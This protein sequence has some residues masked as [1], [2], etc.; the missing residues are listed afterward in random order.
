MRK[1]MLV[2]LCFC[3]L[4]SCALPASAEEENAPAVK[5]NI[6]TEDDFLEFAEK[7]RLDSYSQN[8]EVYLKSDLNLTGKIFNGIPI[9]CG[10]L[11][12]NDHT[13]EGISIQGEGSNQGFFRY[14][15]ESAEVYKLHLKGKVNPQGSSAKAGGFAGSN[16]GSIK[17][18]SFE[19]EVSGSDR[20]GGIAGFNRVD[21]VID[22][23]EVSGTVH[24]GHFVGGLAGENMG[25]IRSCVNDADIN[26]E[27]NQNKVDLSSITL[28]TISGV[29]AANIVTDI[30]GIAGTNGGVIRNCDNQAVVGYLHIGYN[31]GGIA[32]SQKGY[33]FGCRNFGPIFGRKEVGGIVGQMEPVTRIEYTEDTL[34]ILEQQLAGTAALTSQAAANAKNN[35]LSLDGQI[36][37]LKGQAETARDAVESLIPS[38]DNPK[39]PDRDSIVAAKNALDSSMTSMQNTMTGIATSAGNAAKALESDIRAISGQI[40]AMSH[41][42]NEASDHFGATFTD[43]SDEDTED[44]LTGKVADCSNSGPISGDLNA[45]GIIGAIAWE[46][47]LDPEDDIQFSGENSLKIESEIRAVVLNCRNKGKIEVKRRNA[48]GIAGWVSLGLL[49]DCSNS[50]R[51]EAED[52]QY[53]GGI[54]GNSTGFIRSCNSKCEI[55]GQRYVG[56]IAGSGTV[57]TDSRSIAKI[58]GAAEQT[59]EILGILNLSR[60]DTVENFRGNY[61]M[62]ADQDLGAVDG[63][64][65]ADRAESLPQ[66]QFY[67]LPELDSVFSDSTVTFLTEEGTETVI[68]MKP[69][70]ILDPSLI[71]AVPEKAGYV[72]E[73]ENLAET[74]EDGVFFDR[75]YKTSYTAY[76]TAIESAEEREDGRA[77]LLAEGEFAGGGRFPLEPISDLPAT[78]KDET[79]VEGWKVPDLEQTGGIQL[80]YGAPKEYDPELLKVMIQ[81]HDGSWRE[82]EV[83]ISE[84]YLIF[85]AAPGDRAFSVI[86]VPEEIPWLLYIGSGVLGVTLI[87]L[88][89]ILIVR[90]KKKKNKK[91]K[92][93]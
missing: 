68:T 2:A 50:G 18:C 23:C 3:I 87:A 42:L 73:W 46:N 84:S 19:G 47:D 6:E 48:G 82:A 33:L 55:T 91:Q 80:R 51:I 52:V 41:T 4:F 44:E 67:S 38:R 16:A 28:E 43:V 9:F 56:G 63:I 86:A 69:G 29:E 12:G 10:K 83:R 88:A 75:T 61:Y 22:Q 89:V 92:S 78:E 85:T 40:N 70:E 66:E 76:R 57:V 35:A 39:L 13:I 45:G 26:A 58:S 81:D 49:R 30:G 34:Q 7:C 1:I 54:V 31:I 79:A 27:A 24:G 21:G 53:V 25:V 14:L 71:P 5:L 74:G 72:G 20:V 60:N 11:Y 90:K 77:V 15:T 62:V 59:G 32:G 64:C 8:L 17:N 36:N 93:E 37:E 65:Y